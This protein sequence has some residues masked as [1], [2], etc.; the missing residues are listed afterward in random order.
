M[1][2][3]LFYMVSTFYNNFYSFLNTGVLFSSVPSLYSIASWPKL[4][5]TIGHF[6]LHPQIV[7]SSLTISYSSKKKSDFD[8]ALIDWLR[9][10]SNLVWTVG[11]G[12]RRPDPMGTIL[13]KSKPFQ[14]LER[15]GFCYNPG[16]PGTFWAG[17]ADYNC[18]GK[19]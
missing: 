1:P 5:Q 15:D 8:F 18:L 4:L 6:S 2:W 16:Y 19:S 13:I 3:T 11:R 10:R 9:F 7:C 17:F 12:S 14:L